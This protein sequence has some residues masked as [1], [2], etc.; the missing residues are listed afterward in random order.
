[1]A[2]DVPSLLDCARKKL[3]DVLMQAPRR[4]ARLLIPPASD[5]RLSQPDQHAD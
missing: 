2:R 4:S 1:M 3:M 5:L